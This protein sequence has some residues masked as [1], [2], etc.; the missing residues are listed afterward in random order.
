MCGGSVSFKNT[1]AS[2]IDGRVFG[3]KSVSH[4]LNSSG[5]TIEVEFER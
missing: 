1:G 5:Y 2:D 4:S 3:V